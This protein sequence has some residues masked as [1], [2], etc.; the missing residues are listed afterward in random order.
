MVNNRLSE[1]Y[2]PV[3]RKNWFGS[4]VAGTYLESAGLISNTLCYNLIIYLMDKAVDIESFW[5][6][7]QAR[8]RTVAMN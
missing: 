4:A 5:T 3:N 8:F 6:A 2:L 7:M 1:K